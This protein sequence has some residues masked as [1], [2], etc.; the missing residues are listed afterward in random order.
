[1]SRKIYCDK[2]GKQL[3]YR[4]PQF[5]EK[6]IQLQNGEYIRLS[7]Q[8]SFWGEN[9]K[10]SKSYGDFCEECAG[11]KIRPLVKEFIKE[12]LSTL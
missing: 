11:E 7:G 12:Y 1:M 4:F 8:Y 6:T 9:S 5:Y 10:G 2:C 3:E